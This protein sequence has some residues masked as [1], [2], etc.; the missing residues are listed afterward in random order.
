[1]SF[2]TEVEQSSLQITRAENRILSQRAIVRKLRFDTEPR[3]C[4]MASDLL[5]LMEERILAMR[6]RHVELLGMS[7]TEAR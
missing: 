1:M 3:Y 6:K 5:S 4:A 7:E 2:R